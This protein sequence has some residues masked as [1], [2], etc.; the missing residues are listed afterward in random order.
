[1]MRNVVWSAVAAVVLLLASIAAAVREFDI[2]VVVATG[3]A[4]TTC[5]V[6]SIRE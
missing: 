3:L 1:M 5:A 2:K 6:L 4:A